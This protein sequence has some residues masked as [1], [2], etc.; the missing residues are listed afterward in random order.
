[1]VEHPFLEVTYR[2]GKPFAGYLHFREAPSDV[3]CRT[4]EIQPGILVDVTADGQVVGIE[5]LSPDRLT[6]DD[7]KAIQGALVGQSLPV[8]DLAPIMAP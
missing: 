4:E 6:P 2:R 8:E 3:P 1:M 7:V 5:F